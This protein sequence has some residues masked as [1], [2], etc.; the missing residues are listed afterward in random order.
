[1]RDDKAGS[2]LIENETG[3]QR[4]PGNA[5]DVSNP[6]RRARC[7]LTLKESHRNRHEV[8]HDGIA[9]AMLDNALGAIVSLTEDIRQVVCLS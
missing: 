5:L 1:M 9:S 4:L 3:A 2:G 7:N 6:D 8:L